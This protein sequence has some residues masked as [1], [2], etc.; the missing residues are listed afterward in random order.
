[1]LAQHAR[2]RLGKT[3]GYV[4]QYNKQLKQMKTELF[5]FAVKMIL[6]NH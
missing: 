6:D 2:L 4:V 1:M 5:K 3:A